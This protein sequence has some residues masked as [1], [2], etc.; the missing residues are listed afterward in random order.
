M[1]GRVDG[2]LP[3][4][5]TVKGADVVHDVWLLR[6]C[7]GKGRNSVLEVLGAMGVVAGFLL[8]S[9]K[10][11]EEEDERLHQHDRHDVA[12]G[13]GGG[14]GRGQHRPLPLDPSAN[15]L[16]QEEDGGIETNRRG[17]AT[18]RR[19]PSSTTEL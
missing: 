5:A 3:A 4:D 9:C 10:G 8:V 16:D 2:L 11:K 14:G 15:G 13:G 19:F 12:V 6:R 1:G 7:A 17:G 18:A